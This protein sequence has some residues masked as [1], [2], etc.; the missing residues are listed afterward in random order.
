[1]KSFLILFL[2]L[3][4][5]NFFGATSISNIILLGLICPFIFNE[6]FRD[7]IFKRYILTLFVGL[8]ISI[9]SCYYFRHQPVFLTFKV[10]VPY[11]YILFYFVL[12]HLDLSITEA[13]K[14]L[15]CLVLIFCSCY[16]IQFMVYPKVIFSGA[17][18]EYYEDVRIRLAGQG[19]SSLGYFLGLN[20]FI[21]N[22]NKTG[23]LLLSF[24]CFVV[25]FL[26]GFRTMLVMIGVFT[27]ITIIRV[28]GFGQMVFVFG[29]VCAAIWKVAAEI[30]VFA[31][32]IKRMAERQKTD[33]FSN[34]DYIR[35]IQL[36]YFTQNHF[37]NIFEY[38][39]GSG[40]PNYGNGMNS[41]GKYMK[42]LDDTGINY[43][44]WGLLSLSWMIGMVAVLSMIAYSVKAFIMKVPV[45]YCYLGI[46]FMYLIVSSFTTMEFFRSGNFIVQSIALYIVEKAYVEGLFK[47][48]S[49][50]FSIAE[51]QAD[52]S[53]GSI[54]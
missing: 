1:M 17:D 19:F 43:V 44:D 42:G 48:Y 20:K 33:T 4:L 14:I 53:I 26:M 39:C 27:I 32:I 47:R 41:Y 6:L 34:G 31:G 3:L 24:L 29:I 50:N 23:Y 9:L 37:K 25:I 36:R 8:S 52:T 7:S 30:P 11:Y 15:V 51:L 2:S 5:T 46:W 12:K 13:E 28:K 35:M 49:Y 38:F 18:E 21:L 10:S 40:I 16:I 45:G 22:K 54:C